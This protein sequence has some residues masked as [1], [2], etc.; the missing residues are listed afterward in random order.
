MACLHAAAA[1][2]SY[3]MKMRSLASADNRQIMPTHISI[4]IVGEEFIAV[5][6]AK[7]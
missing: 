7:C 6:V 4:V 3:S 2:L 1:A 5:E